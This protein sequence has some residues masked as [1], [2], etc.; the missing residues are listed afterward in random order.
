MIPHPFAV[1]VGLFGF[2]FVCLL[3]FPTYLFNDIHKAARKMCYHE[4]LQYFHV[5]SMDT[6]AKIILM[7]VGS[8][9]YTKMC[10]SKFSNLDNRFSLVLLFVVFVVFSLLFQILYFLFK[11]NF[12]FIL[13]IA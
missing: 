10:I 11:I 7:D 5:F 13:D 6:Q 9:Q 8:C 12:N 1:R 2:F 3:V 4:N